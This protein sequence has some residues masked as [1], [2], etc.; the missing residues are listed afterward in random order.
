MTNST[1][2][3]PKS[4]TGTV[5]GAN[6]IRATVLNSALTTRNTTTTSDVKTRTVRSARTEGSAILRYS[7]RMPTICETS[8]QG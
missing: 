1:S 5:G 8:T 4:A 3:D 2:H 7:P 6:T